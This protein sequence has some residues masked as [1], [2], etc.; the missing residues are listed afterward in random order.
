MTRKTFFSIIILFILALSDRVCFAQGAGDIFRQANDAYTGGNFDEAVKLY[1]DILYKQNMKS[2]ELYYN[3]GN[4]YYRIKKPGKAVLSW[5]RALTVNP[6]DKDTRHNI[7]FIQARLFAAEQGKAALE[8]ILGWL[9]K[10]ATLNEVAVLAGIWYSAVILFLL[11]YIFLKRSIF[12]KSAIFSG[13]ILGL[14]ISWMVIVYRYHIILPRAIITTAAAEVHNGPD[15][16]FKVGFTVTEGT[17]TVLLRVSGAWQ[18][19]GIPNRG[20]KGWVK[21]DT[22]EAI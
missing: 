3:L 1:E 17:E 14:C 16:T 7:R 9:E 13:I 22:V 2:H 19:I 6:R 21:K 18:E 4:A 8:I 11:G 15:E 5:E 10:L 12:L 20:L